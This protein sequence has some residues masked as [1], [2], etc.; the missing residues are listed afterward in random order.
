MKLFSE[1]TFSTWGGMSH[2]WPEEYD[3]I[4]GEMI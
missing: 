4:L 1:M 3:L 2:F